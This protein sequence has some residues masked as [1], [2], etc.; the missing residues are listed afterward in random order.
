MIL[1]GEV[2][3]GG[4]QDRVV[5]QDILLIPNSGKKQV[6]VYCV[7]HGRW[8][9]KASGNEFNAYYGLS[10]KTVRKGAVVNKNQSEVWKRVEEVNA[11]NK[12]ESSTG[13][14]TQLKNSKELNEELPKYIKHFEDLVNSDT[15]Y[16]GFVA[17]TGDTII[18]CDMFATNRLFRKQSAQLIKASA[19]EA[20]TNGAAVTILATSVLKFLSEFMKNESTQ[21]ET[22]RDQGEMLIHNGKKIHINYYKK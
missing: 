8:S 7:E 2:V 4:K 3:A 14:Y 11:K 13:T 19:I 6:S 9:P 18:S 1:A 12:T 22:V 16:I 10:T 5:S 15:S 21:I 17:V 20:I